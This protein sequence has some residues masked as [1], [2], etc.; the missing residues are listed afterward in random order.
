MTSRLALCALLVAFLPLAVRGQPVSQEPPQQPPPA[1]AP[2]GQ[3]SERQRLPAPPEFARL[4]KDVN[5]Q[6]ELTIRDQAGSTAPQTKTVSLMA[7]DRTMGRVRAGAIAGKP[8]APQKVLTNL[9]VDA[10]PT[11]LED[12]RVLLELTIE[13]RPLREGEVVQEPPTLNESLTVIL[14]NGKPLTISQAADPI[15]DRRMTVEVKATILK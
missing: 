4:G 8:D 6:V 11:L 1:K 7:A 2:G 9:N 10:R 13:Y 12:G 14:T 15:T 3:P 5:V